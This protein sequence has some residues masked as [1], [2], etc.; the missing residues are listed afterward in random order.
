MKIPC[1]VLCK[2]VEEFQRIQQLMFDAGYVWAGQLP[3]R[4]KKL[5]GPI[6]SIQCGD[7]IAIR[8]YQK[9]GGE[10]IATYSHEFQCLGDP[11]WYQ[12]EHYESTE[13]NKFG[14]VV[15]QTNGVRI[16]RTLVRPS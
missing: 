5:N 2:T 15:K 10:K 3:G 6:R 1:Q 4:G 12:D 13:I 8:I 7:Y 9:E 14:R 16:F 11:P